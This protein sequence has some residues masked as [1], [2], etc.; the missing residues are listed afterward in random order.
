MQPVSAGSN[1]W[2]NEQVKNKCIVKGMGKETHI[3]IPNTI[4][5]NLGEGMMGGLCTLPKYV[6]DHPYE[7]K[8]VYTHV[9]RKA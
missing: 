5:M 7:D 6:S 4:I 2:V 3:R 8:L 9:S 1:S